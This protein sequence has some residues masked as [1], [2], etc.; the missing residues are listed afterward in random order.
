MG[1][2]TGIGI[3]IGIPFKNNALGGD[4]PYLPPELKARLIGVWDN[5][6]KKNTDADRN[7]IKNK[8]PNAGGDLEILNAAYKLNSGFGEYKE[9]FTSW[10]IYPNIEVTDNVIT[11]NGNFNSTWFIY[12]HANENEI[13]EMNIKV[14]G[15][16][17]GGIIRYFYIPDETA[18]IPVS[19]NIS[20][21]GVYHLPKSKLSSN[22]VSIGFTVSSS[23]DWNNIRIEQLSDFGGAFVTDGVNDII[24]S[25]KTLQE[26][27]VT[28][29]FTIVNMIHQISWRGSSSIPL[30]N[31]IRPTD[32]IY[33][34]NQVA[35]IGKTGIY[36]YVV[37]DIKNSTVGNSHI[38]NTILGDKND[39][40]IYTIGDL[41]QGKFSVQGYID[42]NS[43]IRETSS[44][45]HY[46]TFALLGKATED[47]INL[48]IAYFNLDRT[49]KPDILCNI[50]KQGITNDNHADFNDKLVDYSGNGR[51]V[52]MNN[53]AW[54]GGSGIAAKPFE[55][56]KD[57]TIVS[58]EARQKLT[59]YNEFSYKIKS[60]TPSYYWTVQSIIRDNT[61]YQ[62]TIIT[63]KDCYW[64]NVTSFINSE[65]N[66]ESIRKKYPVL[67]NT[68]TQVII[69]GLDQFEYPEGIEPTN[70]VS[71][72]NL[73]Y[74]GEITITFIPSHKGGLLLDGVNDFGKVTGMPVYKDYTFIIDRQIISIGDTA[75]IVASKSEDLTDVNK[76][77]AFLFEYLDG[78]NNVS[79]WSFYKNNGK[80]AN[81]DFTRGISYQSKYSYNGVELLAGTALD[82]DKL[83]LG[84]LRDKDSR[85]ANVAIYSLM[86]FPY[87]M[88]EFLIERQLKK[89]KLGTLYPDM[90]EFRP[91]I[92]SNVLLDSKPTFVIRGT[93]THLNAGDYVPENSQIWV[94][95]KMNNIADRITK[96]TVNG[97]TIDIPENAYSE[98]TLQY[99]FPF[100]IDKSPQKIGITIEQDENYVLFNPVI[101]SN[102]EYHRLDFYLNNYQKRINIGDYIPKGAYLRANIYLNNN[103]DELTAFI[104]NGV[105][106]GYRR[107]SVDDTV[108]NIRQI[109]NY[110]SPQEVNI[111][112]D[113][114][115]R[116]E[117]IDFTNCYPGVPRIYVNDKSVTWGDKLKV[118]DEFT[119]YGN[120]NILPKMYNVLVKALY[121][122]EEMVYGSIGTIS[123]SMVFTSFKT[124]LL[125]NNEP[126]CILSPR[127]LRI[128][129]SSYKILGYIPDISGHGNHGVI[130]N[131]AYAE[132]S[133]ANGYGTNLG[134][135]SI[136]SANTGKIITQR[137]EHLEYEVLSA[138]KNI[139]FYNTKIENDTFVIYTS[140]NTNIVYSKESDIIANIPAN[141]PTKVVCP[142]IGTI[143]LKTNETP[144]V[145]NIITVKQYGIYE[146]AYC[147]DGVDDFVTIPTTVGGKQVL[148]KVNWDDV[149]ANAIIYDQRG[150]PDEFAIYNAD[151]DNSN[152]PVFA[153]QARNTGQTY[154][155]GIL[156]SNIKASEL[157]A[158]THNITITN[159]LSAGVNKSSPVIGSN[160]VHNDFFVN[161]ALYDFMLFDEIST[162]AK[163][164]ELNTYIGITPKVTLP[165]YYWDN[166]GKKNTDANR[167]YVDEQV[168]L[169]KTGTS[170]NPLENFNISY[171]GMSGYNGY[172]VVFGAS[173]T[174]E[175]LSGVYGYASDVTNTTIH[176]THAEHAGNGLLFSYV[177]KDGALANI[178]EIPAF[179]VTI[180][181]L[182]GNSK[183][184]YRYLATEDATEE[185]LVYL[186]NGTHELAK[187]FAPTEALLDLTRNVWVGIFITPMIEGEVVFDCD[188]TIEVLPEYENGLAYDGVSDFSQ[189]TEI[190]VV[191]DFTFLVKGSLLKGLAGSGGCIARKGDKKHYNTGGY[192]FIYCFDSPIES[193]R[194]SY[195][196]FG[197]S[198]VPSKEIVAPP[199]IG[200]MTKT[201]VNGE[202]TTFGTNSDIK[203][204][205]FGNWS[206]G[207][208]NM[209]IY[210]SIF[211][212]KTISLLEINFLKNLMEK[213]EIID[214]NHPIFISNTEDES[215]TSQD[216]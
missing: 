131:S 143:L 118:G 51:D 116:Y 69:C 25:Q 87:S 175:S 191:E 95:I 31:Y 70:A 197:K 189:N 96:F 89:H 140:V 181:G 216:T 73:E 9:D 102:V 15:I 162:E 185:T 4:R 66:K 74:A 61:S 2:N 27:G 161:M 91:V 18:T 132:M 107:S 149:I 20:E 100:V 78:P 53:L 83:W 114:Y 179:R 177:K 207:Y 29:D 108:F 214:I 38:V 113:E 125:D 40:S 174:W 33:V 186:G 205:I 155:D 8:I 22:R 138:D 105:N 30:T 75:G 36:G 88:S 21:D 200:Y 14:S 64:I 115:I 41:S 124:Y 198:F 180:G 127:L 92:N 144:T 16:P 153:Y 111:T 160:I 163:I 104:F 3:G 85:F 182:E 126:K 90:V 208:M 169:Q 166:Y 152:N 121:N 194:N 86:S 130:H 157:K 196:S 42:G 19:Y 46:W 109:Y 68:P 170:V 209:V 34:R 167:G 184:G 176:V 97:K 112:I 13:N 45:A 63:D 119:F 142:K 139:L 76:Q 80:V 215:N 187:S 26:M 137:E 24:I 35:D 110:D 154:I 193:Y 159:E 49:L 203:G 210:K 50:G 201:N 117:D 141:T 168:S 147:F 71:Y 55:T 136:N 47:D 206:S 148:M 103:V 192:A 93:S 52:Q 59:I 77:G 5:Y 60:N 123:K 128:P 84:I 58:D 81:T 99:G 172:P 17:E 204:I 188:I 122:G 101:T 7:I 98:V 211:Y 79:A 133:G 199:L 62:V 1:T 82:S 37:Y 94:S 213:D 12:K 44:V 146:G 23:Y 56:I 165:N 67:A 190:E 11:T 54:K 32:N 151:K 173:K 72:V 48:I 6:G 129:N 43:N 150:Y 195:Y 65:G 171:E 10:R 202:T 164:K 39:Y 134:N 212:T 178:K 183:F 106:I 120:V 145:G 57:Y 156:N 135:W 158:I 28:K